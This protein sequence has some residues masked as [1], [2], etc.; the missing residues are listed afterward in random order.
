MRVTPLDRPTCSTSA[1]SANN[2]ADQE[3]H[4]LTLPKSARRERRDIPFHT[5]KG[6]R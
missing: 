3:E 5:Q 6:V 4:A 2:T 1:F